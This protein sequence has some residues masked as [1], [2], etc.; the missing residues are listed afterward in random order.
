[1]QP[2]FTV[3]STAQKK[4]N[5]ERERNRVQNGYRT[6]MRTRTEQVQNGYRTD[7]E[8]IRN[9]NGSKKKKKVFWNANNNRMCSSE[10][11]VAS[12]A[13]RVLTK[14]VKH[15]TILNTPSSNFCPA[16]Q[17]ESSYVFF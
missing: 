9:G 11:M 10:H 1:M 8:Q 2:W 13:I 5:R 7:I 15:D 3:Y 17:N 14:D 6:A 4:P 12:Y 16:R